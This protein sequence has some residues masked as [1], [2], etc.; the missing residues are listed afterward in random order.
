[1]NKG[2]SAE[3]NLMKFHRLYIAADD[4]AVYPSLPIIL[5]LGSNSSVVVRLDEIRELLSM[6]V[7]GVHVSIDSL[8]VVATGSLRMFFPR[9]GT[10]KLGSGAPV[11][12]AGRGRQR[13]RRLS[14]YRI[15][16]AQTQLRV[17]K[18]TQKM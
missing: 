2:K 15:S 3:N 11:Q 4:S 5:G 12:G 10:Y 9:G 1:M 14:L 13:R 7:C 8:I 16:L 6:G 17:I 18:D